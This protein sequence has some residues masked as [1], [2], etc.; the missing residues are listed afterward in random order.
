MQRFREALETY[1]KF[2]DLPS[3]GEFPRERRHATAAIKRLRDR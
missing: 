1:Q 3:E 2:M